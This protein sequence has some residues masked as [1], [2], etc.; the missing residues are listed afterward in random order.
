MKLITVQFSPVS[1]Y[2]PPPFPSLFDKNTPIRI[3]SWEQLRALFTQSRKPCEKYK[4]YQLRCTRIEVTTKVSLAPIFFNMLSLVAE[5]NANLATVQ[6][7]KTRFASFPL[8]HLDTN[9]TAKF[10]VWPAYAGKT[11]VTSA[12]RWFYREPHR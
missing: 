4:Q 8:S 5:I 7:P 10:L 6:T 12:K 3:L 11:P 9:S 2:F 1:C